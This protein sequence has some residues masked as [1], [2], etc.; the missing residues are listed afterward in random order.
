MGTHFQYK[1]TFG[2][3]YYMDAF[4]QATE[5]ASVYGYSY[6]HKA[7]INFGILKAETTQTDAQLDVQFDETTSEDFDE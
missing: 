4:Y 6:N 5:F 1:T 2:A 3:A 7:G